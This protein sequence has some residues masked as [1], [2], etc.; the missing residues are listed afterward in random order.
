MEET[1]DTGIV[2]NLYQQSLAYEVE[3]ENKEDNK[4]Q[5]KGKDNKQGG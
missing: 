1:K 3:E 4:K 5:K 2:I